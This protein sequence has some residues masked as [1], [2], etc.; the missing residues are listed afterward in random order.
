[1]KF[2]LC[3]GFSGEETGCFSFCPLTSIS[4]PP[5]H[6]LF[7][8][9][10]PFLQSAPLPT[11]FLFFFPPVPRP[12]SLSN[13]STVNTT[14]S[15]PPCSHLPPHTYTLLSFS[16]SLSR[17]RS[18]S[19]SQQA[20]FFFFPLPLH[21]IWACHRCTAHP[22]CCLSMEGGRFHFALLPSFTLYSECSGCFR[23]KTTKSVHATLN[24]MKD[25]DNV[26]NLHLRQLTS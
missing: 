21:A 4:F 17:L 2:T 12:R 7:P 23:D 25:R 1:M 19:S 22:H 8:S 20:S 10:K 6:P 16:H 5:L 15:P 26:L 9:Q 24:I 3:R 13:H 18:L 11:H 14:P